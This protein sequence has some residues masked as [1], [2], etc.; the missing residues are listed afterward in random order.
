MK[1]IP[2]DMKAFVNSEPW[3][4][5]VFPTE[6]I[7]SDDGVGDLIKRLEC[8]SRKPYFVLDSSLVSQEVFSP[9]FGKERVFVFNASASEP[10][11]GDVD[12]L[13]EI[14]MSDSDPA[15]LLVAAGGGA[16]MD[17]AK[18]TAI[19]TA[20]PGPSSK[21][22][23]YDL[24]MKKGLDIWVL[25]TLNGTGAEITPIAVLRGPEKKLGINNKFV[26]PA[27]AFIDPQLSAGAKKF[28]RFFTLMDCYY[29]HFEITKSKTSSEDALD[30]AS[31]GLMLAAEA[32]SCKMDRHETSAA[33]K[34]AMASVLGGSSS[35]YGRVGAA[36]ALSYGLSN[37]SPTL[38]HSVAVT[39]A[40]LALQDIYPDGYAD[41][42]KFLELNEMPKP[43]ASEYGIGVQDV[44][45]MTK[46]ALGM[47]KLWQ[48]CF[49]DSWQKEATPDF[50]RS[51]YMKI[52]K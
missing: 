22:Q 33:I 9:L 21:Y 1:N 45:K 48:S 8:E 47:E 26:E 51:V 15:D 13:T 19:C 30:D 14:V 39:I 40:M 28:N 43:V 25:P 12:R 20:N 3:W 37:S 35:I 41:T 36:H 4:K 31:K 6:V 46:T 17:L 10:R 49:G 38:P 34:A 18:A 52:I 29:H 32:L 7:C 2:A 11:T 50:I 5:T 42:L 24:E 44:E 27:V 23:G 16:T